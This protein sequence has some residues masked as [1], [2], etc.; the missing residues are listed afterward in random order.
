MP[1]LAITSDAGGE[2][3]RATIGEIRRRWQRDREAR[4]GEIERRR[5]ER[6]TG[7]DGND[8]LENPSRLQ[9][10]S[11]L[12]SHRKIKTQIWSSSLYRL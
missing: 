8:W 12:V 4:G 6:S 9:T 5:A 11:P 10:P 3:E 2:I 1:P 7:D